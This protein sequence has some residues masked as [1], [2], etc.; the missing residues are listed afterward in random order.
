MSCSEYT[1]WIELRYGQ[2]VCEYSDSIAEITWLDEYCKSILLR[3]SYLIKC[4]VKARW[5][6]ELSVR[7]RRWFSGE[8]AGSIFS[9]MNA[10]V[11]WRTC[12]FDCRGSEH[13][14]SI[15]SLDH[16]IVSIL[17]SPPLNTLSLRL[18]AIIHSSINTHKEKELT[19]SM[20]NRTKAVTTKEYA[21]WIDDAT[22]LLSACVNLVQNT[23]LLTG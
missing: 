7:W 11:Q 14:R 12:W 17:R 22:T 19:F 1:V 3:Y 21:N 15:W 20:E 23:P 9:S 18:Y 2:W 13:A 16:C 8:Y 5:P 4:F 10:Q 6:I